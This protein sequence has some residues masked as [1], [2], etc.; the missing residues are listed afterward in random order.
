MEMLFFMYF[1]ISLSFNYDI[2][3]IKKDTVESKRSGGTFY[4]LYFSYDVIYGLNI[5]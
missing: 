1:I 2:F 4:I 3:I 5:N